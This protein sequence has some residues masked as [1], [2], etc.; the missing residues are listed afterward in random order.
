MTAS[1]R[2][3]ESQAFAQAT[4]DHLEREQI[5]PSP[6]NYAVWFS[7]FAKQDPDLVRTIDILQSN[8]QPMTP[9]RSAELYAQYISSG[10]EREVIENVAREVE[11]ALGEMITLLRETGRD[12]GKFGE[13]LAEFSMKVNE[14]MGV[15]ELQDVVRAMV[16]Q[17]REMLER[18]RRLDSDLKANARKMDRMRQDLEDVQKE[19]MTDGLTGIANRKYFDMTLRT[20]AAGAM[21]AGAPLSLLMIDIDH[22]K[23]F[24]DN[25]GHQVG[26]EVIKL[27]AHV[28]KQQV[29]GQDTP[30]RYGGEEFGIILP[31]TRLND[32]LQLGENIRKAVASKKIVRRTTGEHL[33][34][35]TLSVGGAVYRPGETLPTLIE[36]ADAALYLAKRSGRNRVMS[37]S[38]LTEEMSA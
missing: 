37:E 26:D 19:A 3:D 5:P 8:S 21:E 15:S 27:V 34:T 14:Q 16:L 4:L 2:F 17:T 30:A 35:I 20:A 24:N 28:L 18:N 29:K 33:G 32:A 22:F 25:H 38:Q 12:T 1:L 13:T 31:E 6:E 7:Y 9:Q 10:K 36:R 11:T 23:A